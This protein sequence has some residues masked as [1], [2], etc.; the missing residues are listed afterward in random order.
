MPESPKP[1][2]EE[3]FVEQHDIFYT[4]TPL[5]NGQQIVFQFTRCILSSPYGPSQRKSL[6]RRSNLLAVPT[7]KWKRD[8]KNEGILDSVFLMR[9]RCPPLDK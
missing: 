5:G 3:S 7:G 2:T 4:Q 6:S 8:K 1:F 9:V